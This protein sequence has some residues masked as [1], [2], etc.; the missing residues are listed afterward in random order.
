MSPIGD[1]FTI[2]NAPPRDRRHL[3][4]AAAIVARFGFPNWGTPTVGGFGLYGFGLIVGGFAPIGA[5]RAILASTQFEE[6][7]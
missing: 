3:V 5:C 4:T 7:R 2:V 1:T 6:R